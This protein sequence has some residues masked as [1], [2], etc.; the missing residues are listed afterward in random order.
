MTITESQVI[1]LVRALERICMRDAE[2]A[3]MAAEI[4]RLVRDV[5]D[6]TAQIASLTTHQSDDV[7]VALEII[8]EIES[9]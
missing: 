1:A 3:K 6:R 7:I 4:A 2:C 9:A 8:K 5:A